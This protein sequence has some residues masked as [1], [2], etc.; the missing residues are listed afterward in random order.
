RNIVG[1]ENAGILGRFAAFLALGPA[2]QIVGGATGQILDGLD[3]VLAEFHQHLRVYAGHRLQSVI[4]TEFLALVFLLGLELFQ[5]FFCPALQ[6]V[7][8]FFV[9]TFDAGQFLDVDQREFLDR[10]KAFRRQQLA[11][12]FVDVQRFHEHPRGVLEIGLAALGFFLLGKDVDVPAGQLRGEAYVLPAA[13]DRQ[14]ELVVGVRDDDLDPFAIF[15][16]H[17]LGDFGGR[18]RVDDEGRDIRRPRNDVDLLA[19]QFIDHGLHA[20]TAHADA[21]ADRI[22]R[23]IP[24]NHAVFRARAGIAGHRLDLDYA[25]IDFRHF[26]R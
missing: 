22:D 12:D 26:L 3:V 1:I 16:D 19:L 10:G 7:G 2:D 9:E 15:V 21:G 18:Q 23:G 24:G 8:G 25:V 20:R 13:A 4:H 17:D 5:I 11:D 6:L 14:R